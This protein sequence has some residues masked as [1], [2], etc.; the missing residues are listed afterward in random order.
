M[1]DYFAHAAVL[2]RVREALAGNVDPDLA[3]ARDQLL[4]KAAAFPETALLG[5]FVDH[6]LMHTASTGRELEILGR[7]AELWKSARGLFESVG[8]I[9]AMV[10]SAIAAPAAPAS[11]ASFNAALGQI[12]G[13]PSRLTS[14]QAGMMALRGNL[15]KWDHLKDPHP[16]QQDLSIAGWNWGDRFLAR[17][18]EAFV[19]AAFKNAEGSRESAFALGVL[20]SFAGNVAGSAYLGHGVGGPRRSHP[21]RDRIARH[22][23]GAWVNVNRPLPSL[24]SMSGEIGRH[25]G[26]VGLEPNLKDYLQQCLAEAYPGM[27]DADLSTGVARLEE[28]LSLLSV[29]E[30]PPLPS[31]PLPAT[32]ATMGAL[33]SGDPGTFDSVT[34]ASTPS[35]PDDEPYGPPPPP[36]PNPSPGSPSQTTDTGDCGALALAAFVFLALY[37]LISGLV[38][39]AQKK[40]WTPFKDLGDAYKEHEKQGYSNEHLGT[41]AQQL[42]ELSSSPFGY[43]LL[44]QLYSLQMKIW[45]AMNEGHKMLVNKGLIYPDKLVLDDVTYSQF[46]ALQPSIASWPMRAENPTDEA[47][48]VPPL[49]PLEQPAATASPFPTGAPPSVFIDPP[50]A[51]APFQPAP[52]EA[53]RLWRQIARDE[54]DALN[55]DLDADRGYHAPCWQVAPK[56]SIKDHP[57]DVDVLPYTG[58]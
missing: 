23:V 49:G 38:A 45:E 24:A 35:G 12:S 21:R 22:A 10:E 13:L 40:K 5:T 20:A 6:L 7:A 8:T 28:H 19:R 11:L 30:H 39:W 15:V 55:F 50:L 41:N 4:A 33:D 42:T 47:Y 51:P 2:E 58:L 37:L 14:I 54:H 48:L 27:P 25:L 56:T 16:R 9:R 52:A 53:L 34:D 29:F 44:G 17:R 46:T 26:M 1:I 3:S 32:M 43:W 18:T 31:P 57:V 36:G